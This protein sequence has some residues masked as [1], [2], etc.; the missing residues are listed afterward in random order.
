M[1]NVNENIDIHALGDIQH[2]VL[3]VL[4]ENQGGGLK[5]LD[6]HNI[7]ISKYKISVP[8]R[9]IESLLQQRSYLTKNDFVHKHENHKYEIMQKGINLLTETVICINPQDQSA[10]AKSVKDIFKKISGEV[11]IFDPYFDTD[12]LHRL[13]EWIHEDIKKVR[14]ITRNKKFKKS[15][16]NSLGD[17][18]LQIK[19]QQGIHDRYIFDEK[20]FF[21]S[22]TSFNHIGNKLSYILHMNNLLPYFKNEFEKTWKDAK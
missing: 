10:V 18:Q 12:A 9:K 2:Q 17:T 8:P 22:G 15:D 14:I 3:Y 1:T 4:H 16:L 13:D 20:N 19:I 7:L 5:P 6:I 21:Y 11:N